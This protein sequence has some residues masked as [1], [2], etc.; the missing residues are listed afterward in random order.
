M[1]LLTEVCGLWVRGQARAAPQSLGKGPS[2]S[3]G[4]GRRPPLIKGWGML[5]EREWEGG[6]REGWAVGG[7]RVAG[8]IA[9]TRGGG[10]GCQGWRRSD[11]VG[12]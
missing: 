9:A 1:H 2:G 10:V 12:K 6:R 4:D 3:A 8:A 5:L 11:G 7:A